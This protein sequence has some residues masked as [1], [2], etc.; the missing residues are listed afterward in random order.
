MCLMLYK[1]GAEMYRQSYTELKSGIGT[2]KVILLFAL[3]GLSFCQEDKCSGEK[4]SDPN[5]NNCL[6]LALKELSEFGPAVANFSCAYDQYQEDENK[7][8]F[9]AALGKFGR[10]LKCTICH[11]GNTIGDI[12]LIS[13]TNAAEDALSNSSKAVLDLLEVLKLDKTVFKALCGLGGKLLASE[14]LKNALAN[15]ATGILKGLIKL[16][17]ESQKS[18]ATVAADDIVTLVKDITCLLE[19]LGLPDFDAMEKSLGSLGSKTLQ[20]LLGQ[21]I[22]LTGNDVV[23]P[24]ACHVLDPWFGKLI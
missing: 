21:I 6:L 10:T 7:E 20:G 22:A 1:R 18:G 4:V 9:K 8:S 11:I 15:E 12:F 14:C 24:L 16:Y 17:C 5:G 3:F 13:A 23:G 2:M 19:E